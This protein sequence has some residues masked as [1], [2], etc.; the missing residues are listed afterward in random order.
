MEG[1]NELRIEA[2]KENNARLDAWLDRKLPLPLL[3]QAMPPSL[4]Q[5]TF[6]YPPAGILCRANMQ[7]EVARRV[8]ETCPWP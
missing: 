7:R 6:L 3:S 2:E 5:L 4:E 1:P 8:S